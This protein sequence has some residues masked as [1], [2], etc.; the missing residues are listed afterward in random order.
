MLE[1]LSDQVWCKCVGHN[2]KREYCYNPAP[3]R[4][5]QIVTK[6]LVSDPQL[7]NHSYQIFF[8]EQR[9]LEQVV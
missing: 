8:Q 2:I 6:A 4:I 3:Y 7:L 9:H 1:C 5:P